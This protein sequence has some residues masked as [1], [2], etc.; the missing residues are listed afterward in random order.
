MG[1]YVAHFFI[2]TKVKEL[3]IIIISG[4]SIIQTS[5]YIGIQT[6]IIEII[7]ILIGFVLGFISVPC[8]SYIIN[9]TLNVDLP[10]MDI[11]LNAL[12]LAG[13]FV[14]IQCFYS[15]LIGTGFC[16]R[17]TVTDLM[18]YNDKVSLDDTGF[19]R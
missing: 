13:I 16:Y 19:F 2:T 8:Y 11:S 6:L 7:G 3:G 15:V 9:I 1:G 10:L 14:V 4:G 5:L 18:N 12:V 17:T